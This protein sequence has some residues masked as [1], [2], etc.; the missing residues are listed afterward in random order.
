MCFPGTWEERLEGRGLDSNVGGWVP[1]VHVFSE[2]CQPGGGVCVCVCVC[3][4]VFAYL[5]AAGRER[6]PGV[7]AGT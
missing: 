1:N 6:S 5:E 4:C 7:R 2:V 3:A